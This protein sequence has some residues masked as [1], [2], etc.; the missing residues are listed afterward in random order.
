MSRKRLDV[1]VV[2][3]GLIPSRQIAQSLII[4]G[5][6]LVDDAPVTKPGSSVSEDAQLRLRSEL[7][8]FVG[9]GG[10]KINPIFDLAGVTI[11]GEVCLDVGAST[12]GFTDVMLQRG[13]SL[14][15]AVD[16]GT[17]QL[18]EKLRVDQR[19][20]SLEQTH[21]KDL[22]PGFFDPPP[23]FLTLDLSFISIRKVIEPITSSMAETWRGLLLVKPQFELERHEVGKGGTVKDEALQLRAVD[24]VTTFLLGLGY[25]VTASYPSALAGA[26]KG[27]QEYFLFVSSK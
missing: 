2:E 14:V 8:R 18:A 4:R 15:Y 16:V 20:R 21:A 3:R 6:V 13:A 22:R 1:L 5:E 25:S 27:N 9:R 11:T 19:V 23:S 7:P 24:A 17:S 26:K 10:E 12:G